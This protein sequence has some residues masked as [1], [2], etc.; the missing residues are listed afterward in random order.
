MRQA[1]LVFAKTQE[2]SW[3]DDEE[4]EEKE[5]EKEIMS[6]RLEKKGGHW[7]DRVQ[8]LELWSSVFWGGMLA[9]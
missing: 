7:G 4:E 9:C 8:I 2:G 3:E 5:E 6:G 1:Y